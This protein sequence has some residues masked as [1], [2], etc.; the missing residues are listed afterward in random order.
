MCLLSVNGKWEFGGCV[1]FPPFKNKHN[2]FVFRLHSKHK[3][4]LSQI[5]VDRLNTKQIWYFDPHCTSKMSSL[6]LKHKLFHVKTIE[7]FRSM[8]W[9][10]LA[11]QS[12]LQL[13]S[14][15]K[16]ELPR[17]TQSLLTESF[18]DQLLPG[19]YAIS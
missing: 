14:L 3:L 9:P 16:P 18:P 19:N 7:L 17:S 6:P 4:I 10:T 8:T 5:G 15:W 2:C 1:C 13:T 11:V 12:V